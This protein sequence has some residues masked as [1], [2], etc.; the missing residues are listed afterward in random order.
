MIVAAAVVA[1][2]GQAGVVAESSDASSNASHGD[3]GYAAVPGFSLTAGRQRSPIAD[4]ARQLS[5]IVDVVEVLMDRGDMSPVAMPFRNMV[6]RTIQAFRL[7]QAGRVQAPVM[8][9]HLDTVQD[10]VILQGLVTVQIPMGRHQ[11]R[12]RNRTRQELPCQFPLLRRIQ[13]L[14]QRHKLRHRRCRF[15]DATQMKRASGRSLC[16]ATTTIRL[17]QESSS[18]FQNK[19]ECM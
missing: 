14:P 6:N 19:P 11:R 16:R 8:V 18:M 15:L 9:H 17:L 10:L 1:V 13:S 5:L 3:V 12:F 7:H 2:G 4:A